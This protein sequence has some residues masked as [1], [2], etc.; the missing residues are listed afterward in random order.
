MA[1]RHLQHP[2]LAL[3]AVGLAVLCCW[4]GSGHAGNQEGNRERLQELLQREALFYHHQ[5][6][7]FS[8]ITHLE[9]ARDSRPKKEPPTEAELLLVRMK[10]A[11]GVHEDADRILRR[12]REDDIPEAQANTAWY[13]L[14]EMLFRKGYPAAANEAL[15]SLR[16]RVPEE[17]AGN[18][19]LLRA[20]VLMALRRYAEAA[21]A[22]E[23]W[24]GPRALAG[25]AHFNRGIALLRA[26]NVPEAV[27]SLKLVA[28][29]HAELQAALWLSHGFPFL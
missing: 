27:G 18:V 17:I 23:N 21:R 13:E 22:L 12:L 16:G 5:R 2:A 19:Q 11:F 1:G 7:Y 29:S 24:R 15:D 14:A 10:L 4:G 9:S 3:A 6:D 28:D 8:A 25:Y 26:D 20:N